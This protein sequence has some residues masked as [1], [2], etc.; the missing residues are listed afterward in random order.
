MLT[1]YSVHDIK[2]K[3]MW[4][5]NTVGLIADLYLNRNGEAG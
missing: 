3:A 4:L 2:L 1:D 5:W